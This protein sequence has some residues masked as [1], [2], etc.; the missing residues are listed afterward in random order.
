MKANVEAKIEELEELGQN[1]YDPETGELKKL[2]EVKPKLNSETKWT[3]Q[4]NIKYKKTK[5]DFLF[6]PLAW[7]MVFVAIFWMYALKEVMFLYIFAVALLLF[8]LYCVF[9]RNHHKKK[10]RMRY[11]YEITETDLTIIYTKGKNVKV[12][13]LPIENIKYIGYSER[14][15]A[16]GTLYF[17]FPNNYKDILLMIFANS[18]LFRFDEKVFCFFE[19]ED[20]LDL[21][22]Q[23]K[24]MSG[25][26]I[27][28]EKL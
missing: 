5:Y 3:G 12:R 10:K 20:A 25:K 2:E 14:K 19:I 24:T 16:V 18:G 1:V 11:A 13:Q 23:I 8:G 27:L 21:A 4:P 9:I 17:N 15:N 26:D 28:I 22:N 7:F 6:I